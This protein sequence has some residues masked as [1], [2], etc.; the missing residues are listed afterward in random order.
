MQHLVAV[1]LLGLGLAMSP[2]LASGARADEAGKQKRERKAGDGQRGGGD[3]SGRFLERYHAAVLAVGPTEEQKPK[4][5]AAFAAAKEKFAALGNDASGDRK[6]RREKTKPIMDELRASVEAVL[7]A[8]QKEKMN[9]AREERRA[10]R[11][12]RGG[13]GAK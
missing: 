5:E 12:Q 7:T 4:I 8:E 13:D 3:R 9:K 6:A 1:G 2:M 11:G 10:K